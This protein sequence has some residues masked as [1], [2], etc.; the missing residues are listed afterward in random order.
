MA[1]SSTVNCRNAPDTV[2]VK[3]KT[4]EKLEDCNDPLFPEW[5]GKWSQWV[6]AI[7][8]EDKRSWRKRESKQG[9]KIPKTDLDQAFETQRKEFSCGIYEWKARSSTDGEYV[10]YIGCTCRSKGGGFIERINDYCTNGSH[11]SEQIED[12]LKK[13]YELWV[14]FKG[15]GAGSAN[16]ANKKSAEAD[17]NRVLME[18]DYAWNIRSAPESIRTVP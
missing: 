17:E 8:P 5:S 12:A 4:R 6:L 3:R 10:V 2:T 15:S 13:G 18:Y 7:T 9:Y 1:T 14:R 11:K 16:T